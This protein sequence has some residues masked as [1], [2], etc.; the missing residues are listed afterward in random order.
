MTLRDYFDTRKG[1]YER[2]TREQDHDRLLMRRLVFLISKTVKWQK[3][4]Y[5]S[6]QD[7]FSLS[8][9]SEKSDLQSILQNY[10][11]PEEQQ[12]TALVLLKALENG[13]VS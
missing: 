12:Q 7:V 8:S 2:V 13:E 3:E 10:P 1:Y 5:Q 6:E 9:E 4:P 11:S